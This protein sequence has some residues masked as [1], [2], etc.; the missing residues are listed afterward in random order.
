MI[1]SDKI[2]TLDIELAVARHYNPRVNIIVPNISWGLGLHEC[3]LLVVTKAGIAYEIEIKTSKSDVKADRR[4]RHKHQSWKIQKLYFA[5]PH[6]LIE[7]C[8][9]YI[10]E[11]AGIISVLENHCV[12]KIREAKKQNDYKFS[13]K[14]KVSLVRLGAMR[15]WP[16]KRILRDTYNKKYSKKRINYQKK[17]LDLFT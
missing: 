6:Y 4:K 7:E 16:L 1:K 12:I 14:E 11:R 15:I 2:D 10:P 17:Q 13:D 5:L 9:E 3:D 8:E